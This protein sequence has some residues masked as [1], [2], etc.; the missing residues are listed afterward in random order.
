MVFFSLERNGYKFVIVKKV[1]VALL[2]IYNL[3]ALNSFDRVLL[4][5]SMRNSLSLS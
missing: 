2:V 3:P 4:I 5:E 1:W